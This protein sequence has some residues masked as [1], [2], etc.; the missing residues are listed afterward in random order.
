MLRADLRERFQSCDPWEV[1]GLC[2]GGSKEQ[3]ELAIRLVWVL[4]SHPG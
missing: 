2:L 3:P 1:G 4:A